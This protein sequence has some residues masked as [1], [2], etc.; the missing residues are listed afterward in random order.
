MGLR[1]VRFLKMEERW[2]IGDSDVRSL[3]TRLLFILSRC[4]RLLDSNV[5]NS[6]QTEPKRKHSSTEPKRKPSSVIIVP[7]AN[8]A[9][10]NCLLDYIVTNS[11]QTKPKRG[12]SSTIITPWT[13]TA[14]DQKVALTAAQSV[15]ALPPSPPPVSALPLT[16]CACVFLLD[17][18]AYNPYAGPSVCPVSDASAPLIKQGRWS[19]GVGTS[20]C[21][22]RSMKK[23]ASFTN[24]HDVSVPSGSKNESQ[25]P[26]NERHR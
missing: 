21:A 14:E 7:W 4:S 9:M 16:F 11:I 10:H 24:N 17:H 8:S 3:F 22:A 23:M 15:S 1:I 12:H 2:S 20:Q 19:Q 18:A 26:K 5:T 6:I 13:N 25:L